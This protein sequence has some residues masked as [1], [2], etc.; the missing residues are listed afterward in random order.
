MLCIYNF[1]GTIKAIARA[2]L[3]VG[4]IVP[5]I[6]A[7]SGGGSATT[8]TTTTLPSKARGRELLK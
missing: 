2:V 7:C 8:S 6:E 1:L 3:V 4:L 5:G